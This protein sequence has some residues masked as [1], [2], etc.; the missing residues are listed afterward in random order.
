MLTVAP[1][2]PPHLERDGWLNSL[3]FEE[4]ANFRDLAG[5]DHSAPAV[6]VAGGRLRRGMLYRSSHLNFATPQDI[7]FM[8]DTLK[9][10]TYIDLRSNDGFLE[11]RDAKVYDTY[12]PSPIRRE[13][14]PAPTAPGQMR[15]VNYHVLR[16]IG[17]RKL[18]DA[19]KQ[20]GKDV[21]PDTWLQFALRDPKTQ[22]IPRP[23]RQ[24]P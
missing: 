13:G 1:P 10:R 6:R 11:T 20:G 7:A 9:I 12:P 5:I 2:A 16:G 15:R 8:R 4:V 22:R 17:L 19:E 23:G 21:E 14:Q 18:T 24:S 3:G